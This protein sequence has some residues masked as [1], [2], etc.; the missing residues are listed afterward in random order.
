MANP[1]VILSKFALTEMEKR[2]VLTTH[3][4][5]GLMTSNSGQLQMKDDPYIWWD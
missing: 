5:L 2:A 3:T 4:K 1:D